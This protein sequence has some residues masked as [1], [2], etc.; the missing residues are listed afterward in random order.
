[1]RVNK[2]FLIIGSVA[3]FAVIGFTVYL[4]LISRV[5]PDKGILPSSMLGG[6]A[7]NEKNWKEIGV[8]I[9]GTYADAEVVDLGDGKFRMYYSAEPEVLGNKLEIFSA[10]ST[11]GINWTKEV[12]IRKTFATFPD[13]VKL[14]DG[15]W[16]L[17]FQNMGVIKSAISS[18][19]LNWTDET[20]VRVNQKEAGFSVETV[21]AQSTTRLADGTYI[22]VYR[23]VE[24][25]PYGTERLPNQTTSNYFYA[26]STD[27]ITFAKKGLAVDARNE[28]LKG[29]ADGAEWVKWDNGELRLYFWSYGGVY[30]V[31]YKDGVFSNIPIFDFT[32]QPGQIMSPNPPSDP[33]IVKVNGKWLMYYGQHTKGIY[34]A[35]L[36]N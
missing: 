2:S 4:I 8:A 25:K 35:T 34:Y 12:G 26:V 30:H 36:N 5:I 7:G 24:N 21:G 14:P 9:S 3:V 27:G 28:I 33:T 17:Y 16:R 32:N 29:F 13:V 22:M 15:R 1:M 31:V 6:P 23:G 10:T 18:D 20:G 19:G 11:D